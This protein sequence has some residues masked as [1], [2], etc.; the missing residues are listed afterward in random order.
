MTSRGPRLNRRQALLGAAGAGLLA[1]TGW[2]HAPARARQDAAFTT[3]T[4][5]TTPGG[6]PLSGG[7]LVVGTPREPDSLHPWAASTVAAFD[8]LDGVMDGLLR[9]TAEGKL[10]P[11]LAEGFAISADGLTYTFKL[12]QGVRYHNGEPF[13]GE[14][15]V[16]AWE[17]SQD[18]EFDALSTLG[19]QKVDSVDLPD[20][21]TLVIATSEP[22]APFL[23]TVATTYLCPRSALAEGV[24]SFREVFAS[25]PIGTGP[26][27]VVSWDSEGAIE[28]ERWDRYWA[29]P[30]LLEGI[31]YRTFSDSDALLAALQAG[32]I[33]IAGGAGAIPSASVDDVAALP[34]L[35]VFEH[36]TMNWQHVDL[37]QMSFL[38]ETPV[39]QA[40][41]FATPRQAIIDDLLFGHA[42]PAFADQAPDSWAY[43]DT[44]QPR[45]FDPERAARLLDEAGLLPGED[46][47]RERDGKRFEIDLWG[48][49]G[50]ELARAMLE[51]IA[52]E[53]N[54]LGVSTLVQTAPP[55][56]LWGPL[57]YQFS[58]RMTGCLYT[59]TNANDPDDLFYWHSSQIPT[60][61]DGS[62]GNLPAFF[63]PYAFQQ[64]IDDLTVDAA[65]TL[66]FAERQ[67][68]Y[69]EIQALLAREAPVLFLYWEHA[70]PAAREHVG[71]FW[72]SAWTPLLWNAADWYLA[73]LNATPAATPEEPAGATPVAG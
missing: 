15:F 46:G 28:L 26:F 4:G 5:P 69:A 38:R 30:A 54:A 19:W 22:Y 52:A 11:A 49:E 73:D 72:P 47:V 2:H 13:R 67:Q 55:D 8:L 61:P 40:L 42:T 37:K 68:N 51:M 57:G 66:D 27:R 65:L 34:D 43:S 29:D 58:D 39:R 41:D 3:P 60:S 45:P 53:W 6:A 18:R 70:F 9:Y 10:R 17:L 14:D 64:Q 12:R 31:R 36:G 59:W 33:D 48:V 1:A 32:E 25:A 24:E 21:E 20:Q 56:T 35:T 44:L 7:R 23:S 71:G 63:Y 16:A 50:D 62:G